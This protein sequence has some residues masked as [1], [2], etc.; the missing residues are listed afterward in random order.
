MVQSYIKKKFFN[1]FEGWHDKEKKEPTKLS[2]WAETLNYAFLML[3]LLDCTL[4]SWNT[5][6]LF[7]KKSN[8]FHIFPKEGYGLV[9]L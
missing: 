1:N 4:V 2:H 8:F 7:A 3:G 5:M 6:D 9:M